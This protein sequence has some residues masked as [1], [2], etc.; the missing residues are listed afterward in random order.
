MKTR[1]AVLTIVA[2][3]ALCILFLA[4]AG[5]ALTEE[6]S[7]SPSPSAS[8]SAVPEYASP[9]L[10]RSALKA[11]TQAV[12]AR[13]ALARVRDCFKAKAPVR[14][15]QKPLRGATVEAWEKAQRRWT[16]R[17]DDWRGKTKA[18]MAKMRHPG[19]GGSLRWL[20]LV[21]WHWRG[22]PESTCYMMVHISWHE[23]G[24]AEHRW[25]FAGSGAYGIWQ[26]LPKPPWVWDA[27]TQAK[28]ARKKFRA[29][30]FGPWAGCRAFTCGGGCGIK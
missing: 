8:P 29:A 12:K 15:Y 19:G 7:P 17:R 28:A 25:N 26:L 1:M 14:V 24:G 21:R 3:V 16:F 27:W 22:Y 18:G 11:R 6:P 10:V 20:P 23:S 9:A 4:A 2:A 30:G 5:P 13:K